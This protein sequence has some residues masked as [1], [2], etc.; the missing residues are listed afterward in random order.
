MVHSYGTPAKTTKL[1]PGGCNTTGLNVACI[2]GTRE[3]CVM[4]Y[5][6][7]QPRYSILGF[8]TLLTCTLSLLPDIY[9]ANEFA[10]QR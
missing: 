4:H 1:V 7:R 6:I 2:W 9:E 5:D 3:R 8:Y 10:M